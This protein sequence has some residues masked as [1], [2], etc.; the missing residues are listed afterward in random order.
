MSAVSFEPIAFETQTR[1]IRYTLMR[2]HWEGLAEMKVRLEDYEAWCKVHNI[3]VLWGAPYLCM[4]H[5]G[6]DAMQWAMI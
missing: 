4:A 6:G 5:T 2:P 3:K 1:C